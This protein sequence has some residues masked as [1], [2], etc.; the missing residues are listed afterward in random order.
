MIT[1]IITYRYYIS[2]TCKLK[3]FDICKNLKPFK[4]IAVIS[5]V[6]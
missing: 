3:C 5:A 4:K 1:Y 2:V 6:L